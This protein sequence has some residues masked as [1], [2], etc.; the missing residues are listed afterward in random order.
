MST[1]TFTV[2]GMTCNG[3]ANKV[4]GEISAKVS[5]VSLVDIELATGRVTVTGEG[6]DDARIIDVVEEVGYEAVAV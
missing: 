5:G 4:K 3:C 6:L 1:S 2:T